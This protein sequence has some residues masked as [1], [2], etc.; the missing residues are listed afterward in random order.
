MALNYIVW[1]LTAAP[2][3]DQWP[4]GMGDPRDRDD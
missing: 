1:F 2:A 4:R 3:P